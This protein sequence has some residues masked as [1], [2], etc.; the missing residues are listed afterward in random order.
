MWT[1]GHIP[2]RVV[3]VTWTDLLARVQPATAPV[4]KRLDPDIWRPIRD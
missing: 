1:G 3:N 4:Q 2:L